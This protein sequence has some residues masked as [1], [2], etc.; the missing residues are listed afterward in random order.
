[1]K[2]TDQDIPAMTVA[3]QRATER[4]NGREI[5]KAIMTAILGDVLT[6]LQRFGSPDQGVLISRDTPTSV[7]L[8]FGE[9]NIDA[10]KILARQKNWLMV[11]HVEE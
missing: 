6:I 9:D 10:M 5:T 3:L 11:E 4:Y 1:M 8:S 2:P 7:V